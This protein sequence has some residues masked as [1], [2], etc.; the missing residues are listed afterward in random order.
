MGLAL[1]VALNGCGGGDSATGSASTLT[2]AQF[3]RKGNAIC[4]KAFREINRTYAEFSHGPE[5]GEN[6]ASEAERNEA[7][8]RIVPPALNE[9]A[10]DLRNLDA[11]EGEEQRVDRILTALERGIEKG[12]GDPAALRGL[13]GEFALE[14]GY[15]KLWAYGLTGCGLGS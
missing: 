2:K 1:L 3:L 6:A 15:E 12:E 11:P 9:A 13:N 4:G 5:G 7:A 14:D 8:E 10:A